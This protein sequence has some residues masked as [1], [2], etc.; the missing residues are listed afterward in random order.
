MWNSKNTSTSLFKI[1]RIIPL[2]LWYNHHPSPYLYNCNRYVLWKLQGFNIKFS[3]C[4]LCIIL[5]FHYLVFLCSPKQ[6]VRELSSVILWYLTQHFSFLFFLPH[7]TACLFF[8]LLQTLYVPATS[9]VLKFGYVLLIT[10]AFYFHAFSLQTL[11]L[12][13]DTLSLG[14]LYPAFV[15][16]F[17]LWVFYTLFL[18]KNSLLVVFWRKNLV[19]DNSCGLGPS[20][21]LFFSICFRV[22]PY[23]FSN[24]GVHS[25]LGGFHLGI[26]LI[27]VPSL[28]FDHVFVSPARLK[29][30]VQGLLVP[31]L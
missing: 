3:F 18:S 7:F 5:F 12:F 31:Y 9:S 26:Y 6:V 8:C 29:S 28:C 11:P 14:N 22:F 16:L 13:F 21:S 4:Q 20:N 24:S 23:C 19:C 25:Y 10:E 2:D 27:A 17:C 1:E 30:I 15:R